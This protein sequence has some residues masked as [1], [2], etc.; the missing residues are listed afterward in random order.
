MDAQRV[1]T[2]VSPQGHVEHLHEDSTHVAN[3]PL[4]EHR[5]EKIA[6]LTARDR[7][8]GREIARLRVQDAPTSGLVAPALL[9]DLQRDRRGSFDDRDELNELRSEFVAKVPVH[10]EWFVNVRARH[11]TQNVDVDTV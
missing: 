9:G 7:T 11:R 10:R 8:A 1:L 2:K 3:H 5:G 4:V 6:V